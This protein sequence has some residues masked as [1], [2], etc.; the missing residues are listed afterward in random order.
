[1]SSGFFSL[2]GLAQ[3]EVGRA[4]AKLCGNE[5]SQSTV[6]RFE[7]KKLTSHN[8]EKLRPLLRQSLLDLARTPPEVLSSLLA[9]DTA[10]AT[11]AAAA[12]LMVTK[13]YGSQRKKRSTIGPKARGT[14]EAMFEWNYKPSVEEMT[15]IAA[16]L[17]MDRNAIRVWFCNRRQRDKQR[18]A[19]VEQS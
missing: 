10:T 1:M 9:P 19:R 3:S 11:A 13:S 4:L 16:Q 18:Q 8:M 7:C 17:P 6:S 15:G 12:V 14:L 2:Q 5:F